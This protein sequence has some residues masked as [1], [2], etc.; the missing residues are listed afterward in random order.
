MF[1]FTGGYYLTYHMYTLKANI[2]PE[3]WLEDENSF[4]SGPFCG[5]MLLLGGGYFAKACY[6]VVKLLTPVAL[7]SRF[8]SPTLWILLSL[9]SSERFHKEGIY[10]YYIY[11]LF[12][13]QPGWI[14]KKKAKIPATL[15][16]QLSRPGRK[17]TENITIIFVFQ[18]RPGK[19]FPLRFQL[20]NVHTCF[21]PSLFVAGAPW[22]C[23]LALA[24]DDTSGKIMKWTPFTWLK[25]Q[26][27]FNE[28]T[29]KLWKVP[30][31]VGSGRYRNWVHPY[32]SCPHFLTTP[33]WLP[34]L[35]EWRTYRPSS[36]AWYLWRLC[37]R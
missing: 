29:Q 15:P 10:I 14:T 34:N 23:S 6:I 5:D 18:R 19:P 3:K 31:W 21:I 26:G 7:V 16:D 30:C 1:S 9:W 13:P 37:R 4:K 32:F 33:F 36:Y 24:D 28:N 35:G 20:R 11:T 12:Q 22:L 25:K 27:F 17:K 8:T 2:S